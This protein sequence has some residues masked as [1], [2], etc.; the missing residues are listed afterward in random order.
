M[1]EFFN[2]YFE[3]NSLNRYSVKKFVFI[4]NIDLRNFHPK[5][6]ICNQYSESIPEEFFVILFLP[7]HCLSFN[8]VN[9]Y[10]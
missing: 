6:F 2:K 1:K 7:Q 4:I 5:I 10:F 9:W 3:G 8:Q